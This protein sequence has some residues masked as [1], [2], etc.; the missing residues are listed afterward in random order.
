MT[1]P[2]PTSAAFILTRPQTLYVWISGVFVSS[3]LVANMIGAKLFKIDV[4]FFGGFSIIHTVGMV[5]FPITF[6]LTDLV[7]EYYGRRATRRLAYIAFA[8]AALALGFISLS[9]ALPTFEAFANTASHAAFENI[10]GQATIMYV[11]SILAFLV[12]TL[13]DIWIFGIFKRLTRGRFVWFRATGSTVISQVFDSFIVT[14]LAFS[15]IPA[16]LG[17]SA[18]TLTQVV[19]TAATGY[20]LKFFIALA[21]TPLIYLGRWMIREWFG[22]TPVPAQA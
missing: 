2:A 8:M 19:E 16:L 5:P 14:A 21:M 3:L 18:W 15:V 17:S 9:R 11:A 22:M 6:L 12:G 1:K 13:L 20:I 10:F 7:N 4:D